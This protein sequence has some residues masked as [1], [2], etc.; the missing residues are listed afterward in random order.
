MSEHS[1]RTTGAAKPQVAGLLAV[2]LP[3]GYPAYPGLA[4]DRGDLGLDL[5]P[6]PAG[7]AVK[8]GGQLVQLPAG[9]GH[10]GAIEPGGLDLVQLR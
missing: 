5:V 3:G 1:E 8:G 9:L 6:G 2:K 4:G 7:L 10:G